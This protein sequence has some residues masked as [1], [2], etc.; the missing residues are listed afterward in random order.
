MD[1]FYALI[2]AGGGGT[3]LWP[4]SRKNTPKQLLPLVE[5]GS[6]FC[7]SVERLAPLF[8]PDHIYVVT[9]EKYVDALCDQAPEVPRENFIREPFGKNSGPAALLGMTVIHKRDPLAT[10]VILTADHHIAFKDVFRNV[11]AGA[12]ELAQT[13]KIVTLG[14]SPSFPS[15][16]FGYIRRGKPEGEYNGFEAY[17][18]LGFTEKPNLPKAIE[19]LT[20]GEYSWNSGM[21]IWTTRQ[22]LDEYRR[23]QP[24]M[25][26]AIERLAKYV[27]TPA[28]YEELDIAWQDIEEIPIDFAVMEGARD[29]AVIPVDMGWSDVGSWDA[30][31]DVLDVDQFGNA[32]KGQAPEPIMVDTK[33]TLVYSDKLTVTIGVEDI[34][35]VDT[36]DAL[37]ICHKKRAQDV[38]DVVNKLRAA[39]K[40]K[41]L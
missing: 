31:F 33:N 32:F 35:V 14:I 21:F 25:A 12:Y 27:D 36:P 34:V 11:L 22:A 26:A 2:M 18:S 39:N 16:A 13:G 29:M 7:V 30:L 10:V 28:F 41:Y 20:S 15:T 4:A 6:M 37:M 38:K 17:E 9:G 1:H 40:E 19:F 5:E 24:D 3:R 23:Q 8:Q